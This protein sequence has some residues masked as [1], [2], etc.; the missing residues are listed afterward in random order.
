M[1]ILGSIS[2]IMHRILTASSQHHNRRYRKTG[3]LL[4]RAGIVEKRRVRFR[5]V[6]QYR[7]IKLFDLSLMVVGHSLSFSLQSLRQAD[8]PQQ[9]G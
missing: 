3:H 8:A 6:S 2:R 5:R 9:V 4:A 1:I 7:V